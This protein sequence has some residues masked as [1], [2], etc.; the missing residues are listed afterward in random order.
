M[1]CSNTDS[2][3]LSWL[4]FKLFLHKKSKIPFP[5]FLRKDN[6]LDQTSGLYLEITSPSLVTTGFSRKFSPSLT[7]PGDL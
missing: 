2:P 3:F 5:L 4:F 6:I 7:T 1:W